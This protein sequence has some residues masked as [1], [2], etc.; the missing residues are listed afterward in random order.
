MMHPASVILV[1]ETYFVPVLAQVLMR[2]QGSRGVEEAHE[3]LLMRTCS[4]AHGLLLSY[5][6]PAYSLSHGCP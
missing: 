6:V 2:V 5:D 4:I 1:F 3:Y